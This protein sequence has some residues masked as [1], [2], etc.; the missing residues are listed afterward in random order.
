MNDMPDEIWVMRFKKKYVA[1]DKINE[2]TIDELSTKYIRADVLKDRSGTESW[3]AVAMRFKGQQR[4]AEAKLARAMETIET[5]LNIEAGE[6]LQPYHDRA[7]QTLEDI[8]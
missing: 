3:L 6:D 5:L 7:K 1:L 4:E 8:T 2:G